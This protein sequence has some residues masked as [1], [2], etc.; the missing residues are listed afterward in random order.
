MSSSAVSAGAEIVPA[1]PVICGP[2]A[3]GKS[4]LAMWIAGRHPVE[5]ISA[6]SRQVYRGF[7][8]GTAKPS[9][10]E[11]ER[12]PH[13]GID[14]ADPTA[15]YSAAEWATMAQRAIREAL[16][17]GRVPVVVG[18]TG[19]Y[20]AA[21]FRPLWEQPTLDPEQRLA[22]QRHLDQFSLDELR[23]WCAA[24]DPARAHFGRSQLLR[25]IE[26]ALLMGQRLSG[27]HVSRARPA[28][29]QPR[30]LL[31]D[32]GTD[33]HGRIAARA[34][35]M[36]EHGWLDEVRQRMADVPEDAPAWNATGYELA[37]DHVAG[38]RSREEMLERIVIDTRQYA[39]RQRTWFRHQL[40]ADRVTRV[41]PGA[42]GWQEVVEG[43]MQ[44][45]RTAH[46]PPPTAN[47]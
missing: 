12:V 19:F 1:I 45:A 13:H 4:D 25:S 40:E 36:L 34:S 15:R 26:V 46:R 9:P 27:M 18:G 3:S 6:D 42:S 47:R 8:V 22:V 35:A 38:R 39:K 17:R 37:R 32:P 31:V 41:D 20:V 10:A 5:I 24:L 14:V 2:T 23:R 30:Y 21:L 29:W 33:L 16:E 7:D 44:S 11:R 28:L 43:W